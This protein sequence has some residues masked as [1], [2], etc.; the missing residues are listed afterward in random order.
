MTSPIVALMVD[1][2]GKVCLH[3]HKILKGQEFATDAELRARLVDY[4]REN[5]KE[6]QPQR[7]IIAQMIS[8]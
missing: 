8:M 2:K 1:D 7:V 3:D 6:E 4:K 5:P